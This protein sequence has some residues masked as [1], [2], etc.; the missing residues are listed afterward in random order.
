MNQKKLSKFVT[1]DEFGK[2]TQDFQVKD[3]KAKRRE[4]RN[5]KRK[6]SK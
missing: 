2:E 4:R 6:S 3:G 1:R 5:K